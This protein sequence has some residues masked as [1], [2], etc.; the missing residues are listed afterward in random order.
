MRKRSIVFCLIALIAVAGALRTLPWWSLVF[1]GSGEVRLLG[2]D[3]F[4]QLRHATYIVKNYP[5]IQRWGR[6]HAL[7]HR[8]TGTSPGLFTLL[9]AT[10]ALASPDNIELIAAWLPP[11]SEAQ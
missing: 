4:Y 7:P 8:A 3:P 2:A 1:S 11:S 10:A 5:V 6:C 9:L